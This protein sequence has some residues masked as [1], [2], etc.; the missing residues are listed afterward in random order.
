MNRVA[1]ALLLFVLAAPATA[2]ERKLTA[3]E[4]E[5]ALAGNTVDG[6]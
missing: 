1:T 2:G 4:I 6:N 3:A 5:A